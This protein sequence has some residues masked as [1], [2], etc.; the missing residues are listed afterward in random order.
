[1]IFKP[2]PSL[3]SSALSSSPSVLF[4]LLEEN[5][6]FPWYLTQHWLYTG[7]RSHWSVLF[8]PHPEASTN[9]RHATNFNPVWVSLLVRL[10][11]SGEKERG[12]EEDYLSES[13]TNI[14]PGLFA[15]HST[16]TLNHSLDPRS[17]QSSHPVLYNGHRDA[18]LLYPEQCRAHV[19]H[20][21]G[22][23]GVD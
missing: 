9:Y 4:F 21:T 17:A 23:G 20:L 16:L 15:L 14:K 10:R 2:L 12:G 18:I 8:R 19:S 13:D 7:S 5:L 1:M 11:P 22:S 6:G 3:S